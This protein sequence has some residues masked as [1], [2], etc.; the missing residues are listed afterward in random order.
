MAGFLTRVMPGWARRDTG[1]VLA[2]GR[3]EMVVVRGEEER[4][5]DSPAGSQP[6][7]HCHPLHSSPGERKG[8][9][10][11]HPACCGCNQTLWSL[12]GSG[13]VTAPQQRGQNQAPGGKVTCAGDR[14]YKG[15]IGTLRWATFDGSRP[16]C[17]LHTHRSCPEHT[18]RHT[19]SQPRLPRL[20]TDGVG[21]DQ[22]PESGTPPVWR[23]L[24]AGKW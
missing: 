4:G 13:R 23:T 2:K 11:G 12:W 5:A 16:G 21:T 19:H 7:V 8:V 15:A 24:L 22:C 6:V 1:L 18:P 17:Y 3:V 9:G 14:T 20:V 10:R